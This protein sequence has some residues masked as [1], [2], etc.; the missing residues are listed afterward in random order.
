ME[1]AGTEAPRFIDTPLGMVSGARKRRLVDAITQ[2]VGDNETPYQ[3]V[4]LLTPSEIAGVEDLL[5]ERAGA[6]AT[7]SFNGHHPDDLVYSWSQDVPCSRICECSH[8][9]ECRTC[10]RKH[11]SGLKLDFIDREEE[12]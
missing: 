10:A 12:S 1:V 9:Q 11:D 3:V 5:D 2:P 6:F 4:L 8:R 7:V